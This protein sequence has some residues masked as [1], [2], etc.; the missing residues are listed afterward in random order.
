[1]KPFLQQHPL[2]EELIDFL[3]QCLSLDPMKRPAPE[4][5]LEHPLLT[6][7]FDQKTGFTL[8]DY[9]EED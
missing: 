3:Q 5:L 6:R 8:S 7:K 9:N 2:Y 1:M 4:E